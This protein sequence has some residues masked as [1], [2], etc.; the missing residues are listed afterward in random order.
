MSMPPSTPTLYSFTFYFLTAL[1]AVHVL[2]GVLPLT[3]TTVRGALGRYGPDEHTGVH[4]MALYWHFLDAVWLVLFTVLV[5][6]G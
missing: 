6:V 2:G 5:V 1:H 3:V 4:V